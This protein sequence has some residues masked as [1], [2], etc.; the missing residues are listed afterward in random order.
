[1]TGYLRPYVT[2]WVVIVGAGFSFTTPD[3]VAS[4]TEVVVADAVAPVVAD[5]IPVVIG[6]SVPVVGDA[7][8]AVVAIDRG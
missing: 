5:D 1:M 4:P 2:M 3:I 8:P 6:D 7:T